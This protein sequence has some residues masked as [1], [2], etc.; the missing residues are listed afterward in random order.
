MLFKGVIIRF[1]GLE[2]REASRYV[3][4]SSAGRIRE[5]RRVVV[6]LFPTFKV[7]AGC[8]KSPQSFAMHQDAGWFPLNLH[9]HPAEAVNGRQ[10]VCAFQKM[11]DLCGSKCNGT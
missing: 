8:T 6:P 10:T 7:E 5:I 11:C 4:Q 3:V 1:I 9:T 2:F